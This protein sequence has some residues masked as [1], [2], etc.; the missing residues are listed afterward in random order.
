MGVQA[1][2]PEGGITA[3]LGRRVRIGEH[4]RVGRQFARWLEEAEFPGLK[5]LA[6]SGA[7]ITGYVLEP[8]VTAKRGRPRIHFDEFFAKLAKEYGQKTAEGSPRPT[9][10]LA[11]LRG[12]SASRMRALLHEARKRGLLTRTSQGRSG[13]GLTDRASAILVKK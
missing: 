13:G 8:A 9:A 4:R 11:R 7:P 10:D 2:V 12:L 6:E 3:E 1:T 5:A